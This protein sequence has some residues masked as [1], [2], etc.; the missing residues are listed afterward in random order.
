MLSFLNFRFVTCDWKYNSTYFRG[1][2]YGVRHYIEFAAYAWW[3]IWYS[4]STAVV[5]VIVVE[6]VATAA[7]VALVVEAVVI[8]VVAL[9]WNV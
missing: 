2:F 6:A 8:A 5:V 1:W 4:S 7:V 3:I 9:H